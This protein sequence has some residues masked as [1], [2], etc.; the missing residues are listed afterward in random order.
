MWNFYFFEYTVGSA[1]ISIIIPF[2]SNSKIIAG[3]KINTA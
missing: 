3:A 2:N 1:T